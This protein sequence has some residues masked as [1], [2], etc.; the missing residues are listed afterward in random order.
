MIG[1]YFKSLRIGDVLGDGSSRY[2]L[3]YL[4]LIP[5]NM[6]KSLANDF[7]EAM[8][9]YA[10]VSAIVSKASLALRIWR[11]AC[12]LSLFFSCTGRQRLLVQEKTVWFFWVLWI[13]GFIIEA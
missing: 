5:E 2:F 12:R 10:I 9:Y 1:I 4:L 7:V 3:I 13:I 11:W 6:F 8:W